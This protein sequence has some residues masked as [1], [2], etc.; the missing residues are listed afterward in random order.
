MKK[1]VTTPNPSVPP[2]PPVTPPVTPTV[3]PVTPPATPPAAE[4][5]RV[6]IKRPHIDLSYVRGEEVELPVALYTHYTALALAAGTDPY[7]EKL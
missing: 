2:V 7:F 3:P 1:K 6:K 5:V 4:V